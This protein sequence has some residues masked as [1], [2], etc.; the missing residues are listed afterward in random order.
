M[1][2]NAP[3]VILRASHG[4]PVTLIQTIRVCLTHETIDN[5]TIHIIPLCIRVCIVDVLV[6]SMA[7]SQKPP[8]RWLGE[9]A[10]KGNNEF[11]N[12]RTLPTF[13]ARSAWYHL[14]HDFNPYLT[15]FGV[16]NGVNLIPSSYC[17]HS[18]DYQCDSCIPN[19]S[20][21]PPQQPIRTYYL[22]NKSSSRS[23]YTPAYCSNNHASPFYSNGQI[24]SNVHAQYL[25]PNRN[26]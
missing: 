24:S 4:N 19:N 21:R 20:S 16:T 13:D 22:N 5:E 9:E 14:P 1:T 25:P 23:N 17:E 3:Y 10:R 8:A 7:S 11:D 26:T 15:S 6:Y 12:C 2:L 18:V